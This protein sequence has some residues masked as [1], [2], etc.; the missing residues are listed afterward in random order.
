MTE[1]TNEFSPDSYNHIDLKHNINILVTLDSNYIRYLNVMLSSLLYSNPDTCFNVFILHSSIKNDELT[2]TREI[3]FSSNTLIPIEV[4]D[5]KLEDVPTTARY[6]R[7]IYYRIFA[8]EFLPG[9]IE[10]VLYLDPDIIINGSVKELYNMPMGDSMFA[11]A[12]HIKGFMH[13]VNEFRLNI[14]EDSPYIN[15]GVMLMNLRHLR[16]EQNRN[17]VY[18]FIDKNRS[19]LV[20]PDQDIISGL[21]GSRIIPID[22]YKYNMTERLLALHPQSDVRI[23]VK[24]VRKN[25]TVIHYCGRNKPWKSNYVGQLGVFYKETVYRMAQRQALVSV[26]SDGAYISEDICAEASLTE[27][28]E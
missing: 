14:D 15:S 4:S 1:A 10:R 25:S 23:G 13:K 11:A 16:A 26:N 22:P 19:R 3:L 6:P 28:E 20:L 2:E 18:D 27:E 8:A 17:E 24:W 5:L 12:S 7:E 9:D 21:Y